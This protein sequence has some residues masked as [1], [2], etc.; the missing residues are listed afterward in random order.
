MESRELEKI[1]IL[2]NDITHLAEKYYL[3][4]KLEKKT[5]LSIQ[6]APIENS[7]KELLSALENVGSIACVLF[8]QI[9]YFIKK[10]EGGDNV[11]QKS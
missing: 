4:L 5:I 11:G 7:Y 6:H 10:L 1:L 9:E 3:L 2:L 8:S